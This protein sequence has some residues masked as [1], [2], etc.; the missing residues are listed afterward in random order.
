MTLQFLRDKHISYVQSLNKKQD[1]LEYWLSE[2][3]RMSG[4]YWGL[5]ALEIMDA[6][7]ALPREEMIEFVL[8]CR[9]ENGGFGASPGHDPHILYT[10]S[11]IQILLIQD[12]LDRIDADL[13]ASYICS[14]QDKTTGGVHG[15][16]TGDEID[17]RFV[18]IALQALSILDRL[19]KSVASRSFSVDKSVEYIEAC[20]NYDGGYGLAPGAESHSGQIF[21]CIAAL[22]IAGRLDLVERDLLTWWLCERQV[23]S[24][25]LNGRPEKLPDVCYSWWVLSA[26]AILGRLDW[27]DKDRLREF[28]LEAQDDEAGGIADRKGD[29]ADV[30]HTMFGIA[31]LSL[32][33]FENLEPIDPVYALP[34]RLTKKLKHGKY[35][36]AFAKLEDLHI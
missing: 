31:G 33:G 27:I 16:Q 21:T 12:A 8:S 32:L 9:H 3:L 14:L 34:S 28:I 10:L 4:I 29:V 1:E 25:G 30:F 22:A 11:A 6:G 2:H 17:T 26:L 13:V 7:D 35:Q 24:G 18:Y 36:Q 15:D 23:P 5:M 19:E 20:K